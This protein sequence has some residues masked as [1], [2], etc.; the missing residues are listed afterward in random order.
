MPRRTCTNPASSPSRFFRTETSPLISPNHCF[1]CGNRD[2]PPEHAYIPGTFR[3]DVRH[4]EAPVSSATCPAWA[5]VPSVPF[6]GEPMNFMGSLMK[7]FQNSPPRTAAILSRLNWTNRISSESNLRPGPV[8]F[9]Y[10]VYD[11][12]SLGVPSRVLRYING[13]EAPNDSNEDIDTTSLG[14]K[15][16]SL[17][18]S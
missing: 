8:R 2:V 12:Y 7:S 6:H 16:D 18:I 10:F 4:A 14:T 15:S 17:S 9:I 5:P 1:L 3:S 13:T 11:R